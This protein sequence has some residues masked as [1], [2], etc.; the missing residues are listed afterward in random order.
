MADKYKF[1]VENGPGKFDLQNS[2][3]NGQSADQRD[4]VDFHLKGCSPSIPVVIDLLQRKGETGSV[5]YF[6]GRCMP[7]ANYEFKVSGTY[8]T[9]HREGELM[10]SP[11]LL[12]TACGPK[13]V[14]LSGQDLLHEYLDSLR[15]D[16]VTMP[17]P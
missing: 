6:E 13:V 17:I 14:S 1:Q 3:F 5:W 15:G 9:Q 2:L 7:G 12:V 8:S 11:P 10:F 16:R 4:R